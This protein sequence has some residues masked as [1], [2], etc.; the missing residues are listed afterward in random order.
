MDRRNNDPGYQLNEPKPSAGEP[1]ERLSSNDHQERTLEF[2]RRHPAAPE[3][4][5]GGPVRGAAA[6]RGGGQGEDP[7]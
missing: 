4:E 7:L 6:A 1:D 3:H 5:P 2:A